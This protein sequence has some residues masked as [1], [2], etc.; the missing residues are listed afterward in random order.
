MGDESSFRYRRDDGSLGDFRSPVLED[1]SLFATCPIFAKFGE[2]MTTP[3]ADL[4]A[5]AVEARLGLRAVG[6]TKV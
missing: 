4:R 1:E 2:L 3:L 6:F 5:R